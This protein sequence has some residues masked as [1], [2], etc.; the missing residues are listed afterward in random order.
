[1][2][3]ISKDA[4]IQAAATITA[5]KINAHAVIAAAGSTLG[6]VNVP[7]MMEDSLREVM[8]ALQRTKGAGPDLPRDWK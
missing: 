7:T 5:A 3:T 4:L 1:M 6:A 2:S 8:E